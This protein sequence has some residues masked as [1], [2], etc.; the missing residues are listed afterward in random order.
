[1]AGLTLAEIRGLR[2]DMREHR[3]EILA[4]LDA[5]EQCIIGRLDA[6]RQDFNG[7][8]DTPLPDSVRLAHKEIDRGESS[9]SRGESG[10][11][12]SEPLRQVQ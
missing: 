4:R 8:L 6:M 12:P 7:G 1:M 5:M 10:L 2:A 9:D 3:A 11:A